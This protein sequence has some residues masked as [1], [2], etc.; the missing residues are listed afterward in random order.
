MGLSVEVVGMGGF[1]VLDFVVTE[2]AS[3]VSVLVLC[4]CVCVC[5]FMSITFSYVLF[6]ITA[7]YLLYL[8]WSL[9]VAW[10]SSLCLMIMITSLTT[11]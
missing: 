11:Y 10:M 4:V 7:M 5:V 1:T 8:S 2:V 6:Q 3:V 9:E